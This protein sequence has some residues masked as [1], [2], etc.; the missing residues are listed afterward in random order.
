MLMLTGILGLLAA[1]VASSFLIDDASD[2]DFEEGPDQS[3]DDMETPAPEGAASLLD[4]V[5]DPA[6]VSLG[7]PTPSIGPSPEASEQ[8]D[9]LWGDAAGDLIEG[10]AGNDQINGY[11][12]DDTL[13][14]GAGED[15]LTGDTGAD[16]LIGGLAEDRLEGEDG[17]DVLLGDEGQDT[18]IGGFGN[19]TL[20]GGADEDS[21]IGGADDDALDGGA[22]AD[23]L[24][25]NDGDDLLIGGAGKDELIGGT[26]NDT[27]FGV[28]P[29]GQVDE[30][31][32]DL[33]NGNDGD[34]LLVLGAGD[35]AHGGEGADDFAVGDWID[36]GNP[37]TIIDYTAGEDHLTVIYDAEGDAAPELTIE[38]S[39]DTPDAAWIVLNGAR[40]A[41]VWG[42]GELTAADV[43]LISAADFA[44]T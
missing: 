9:I 39:E 27:L 40:I 7:V 37:A 20:L 31:E 12:G 30:S 10:G 19:D 21:L 13:V 29:S 43:Q 22:G 6:E 11:E 25:G 38:P 18:L 33:L 42:A 34:D 35:Y 16:I 41:E 23:T 5:T 3:G 44:Q 32:M 2:T 8:D 15:T 14:G 36:S 28:D 24:E 17:A 26:G 1:G 4:L